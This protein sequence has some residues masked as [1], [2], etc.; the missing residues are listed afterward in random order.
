[1]EVFYL[2]I[3]Y[4]TTVKYMINSSCVC[5]FNAISVSLTS[6]QFFCVNYK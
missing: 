1:M 2:E 3:V 5:I 4:A 6:V